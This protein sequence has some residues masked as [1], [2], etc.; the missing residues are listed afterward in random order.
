MSNNQPNIVLITCDHLRADHLGCS[1]NEVIQTPHIDQLAR[2]GV[3]FDQAYSTTPICI[4]A[5]A[6]IMTGLEGKTMGVTTFQ[7]GFELPVKETLPQLLSNDG[8]QTK[9]VGKMHVYPERCHYGFDDMLLC[10]EGRLFGMYNGENRGY[11]DYEL[12]LTEQGYDGMAFAHGISVNEYAMSPW[13]LPN[14]LHPTEW[15]GLQTCKE[16]KRR[17]W[18]RPLFMWASFTAPHPPLTPL[19]NDLFLYD[20]D[21]MPEPVIGDWVDQHPSFHTKN[22]YLT[23]EKTEKQ[24]KL[25]KQAFYASITQIDRQINRII[26]TL[27]EQGMLENTWIIFASDHGESLGDHNL[28]QKA[29]FLKGSC[30]IPLIITPPLSGEYDH[31]FSQEWLP[32]KVNSSVVGLQDLLPTCLDISGGTIPNNIDGKSL[33][34][35]V[36]DSE[37]SVRDTILGEFGEI[38]LRSLMI[39]DGKWKYIWYEEDGYEL[40]FNLREDPN[41]TRNLANIETQMKEKWKEKLISVLTKREDDPAVDG[42]QLRITSPGHKV[43]DKER[44]KLINTEWAYNHP[45]GH[46]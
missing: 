38:G 44:V 31:I 43:S 9:V 1:G 24:I 4:P 35:L 5:R 39:T 29:N 30:N 10:E 36:I 28:W 26:G 32:G 12:W 46:H 37:E 15:I 41:E 11:D 13:H 25:A 2:N 8:Y 21:E 18:T 3:R 34:P 40:L 17:D 19:K 23:E 20:R 22:L 16:I 7:P 45:L 27:R 42:N 6:T 33:L 14:H